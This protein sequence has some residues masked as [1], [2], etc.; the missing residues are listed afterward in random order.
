MNVNGIRMMNS[1][2]SGRYGFE[3]LEF[4]DIIIAKLNFVKRDAYT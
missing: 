4:S 3:I 1:V 2:T